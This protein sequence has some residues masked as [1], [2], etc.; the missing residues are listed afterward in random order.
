MN[1]LLYGALLSAAPIAEVRGGIPLMIAQGINPFVAFIV[2]T[3]AN[4]LAIPLTYFFLTFLHSIFLRSKLYANF[5]EYYINKTRIKASPAI[6]RWGYL[7]L[8]IFVAIPLPATGAYTGT[9]VAWLFNMK[10]T[11]AT[12]AIALGVSIAAIIM[13]VISTG[14]SAIFS[15]LL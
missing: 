5:F 10:K 15:A 7:G 8:A 11:K 12:I 13:T 3:I 1:P 6:A 9:L 4:C 2:G 14:A